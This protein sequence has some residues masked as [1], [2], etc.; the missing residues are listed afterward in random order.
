MEFNGRIKDVSMDY[1]SGKMQ[2]TF[3][4]DDKSGLTELQ[5]LQDKELTVTAKKRTY[6]RSL[7]A[8]A[9]AWVL[10]QAIAEKVGSSKEDV[11]LELLHKYSRSFETVLI[12]VPNG[13]ETIANAVKTIANREGR[14]FV[15]MGKTK[16]KNRWHREIRI[17]FGMSIFNN[18][19]MRVFLDGVLLEC[20][21]LRIGTIPPAELERMK[22]EWGIR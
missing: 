22:R 21:E 3:L 11:Y 17:Y 20:R 12:A 2:I 8:N 16:I 9:Y 1:G 7:R 14:T 6:R 5:D 13:D 19:E 4:M 15:D 18:E 10:M